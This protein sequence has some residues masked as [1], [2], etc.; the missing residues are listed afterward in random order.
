MIIGGTATGVGAV[1]GVTVAGV[2]ALFP[3]ILFG[4][5]MGY[6]VVKTKKGIKKFRKD[7]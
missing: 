4:T 3:A 7:K 2:T 6:I 1:V 5:G